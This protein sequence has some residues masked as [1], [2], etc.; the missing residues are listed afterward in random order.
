M[1]TLDPVETLRRVSFFSGL[2]HE[3]LRDLASHCVARTLTRDEMLLEEGDSNDGLFVVQ[4]GAI[5]IF[6]MAETGREQVLVV[7]RAGSTV[8]EL[9]LFDG[10]TVP[11]SAA[12]LVDSTLL[13]LPKREFLELCRHNPDVSFAV[14]LSLARRFRYL[15]SLVEELSLK[16]VSHRLARF[17]R[18]RALEL[19]VRTRRGIEFPL[20]E[21]NQQIAAEIGTVRDLVSRNLKRF[22]DRGIIKME[23]RKVIVLDMAELEVQVA[24]S[25]RAAAER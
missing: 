22:V 23:R 6:K 11:A 14:I 1:K 24:G 12:A 8:G 21:T 10:G 9:P 18:D 7:E 15:T 19:G 17:L 3:E 4:S 25:K 16:E 2:S 5:K 13:Y 20:E